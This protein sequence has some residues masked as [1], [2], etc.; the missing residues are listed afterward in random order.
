VPPGRRSQVLALGWTHR[1]S[2]ASVRE[3]SYACRGSADQSGVPPGRR[4]LPGAAKR[5]GAGLAERH[6]TTPLGHDLHALAPHHKPG[7][8]GRSARRHW[9]GQCWQARASRLRATRGTLWRARRFVLAKPPRCAASPG[10]TG[11]RER[12]KSP[13][14]RRRARCQPS[15]G[16]L[17]AVRERG[18]LSSDRAFAR[19]GLRRPI[20]CITTR[21]Q[22]DASRKCV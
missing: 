15:T 4:Q 12:A 17:A 10:A 18:R 22:P 20:M 11:K 3:S 8:V 13:W 6:S 9:S 5:G 21:A 16:V 19:A 7:G 1:N 14:W 2:H